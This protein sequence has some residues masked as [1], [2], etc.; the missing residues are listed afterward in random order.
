MSE[1]DFGCGS[2]RRGFRKLAPELAELPLFGGGGA[3]Y[4][5]CGVRK[6]TSSGS[7][8]GCVPAFRRIDGLKPIQDAK[9]SIHHPRVVHRSATIQQY[10]LSLLPRHSRA[11]GSI[12][13]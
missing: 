10:V 7:Q 9:K 6:V 4:I 2:E 12:R 5:Q 3:D 8:C 13:G 11:V 1:E